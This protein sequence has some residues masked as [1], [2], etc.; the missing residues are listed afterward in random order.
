MNG[1][2]FVSQIAAADLNG[3][4]DQDLI[5][6]RSVYVGQQ[7][8][9]VTV[10]VGDGHGKFVDNTDALF[11]GN[12]PQTQNARE[13]VLADF[14]HDG[15]SDVFVADHG[16]D[17]SP[18]PGF[19]NTLI[20]SAPGGTL[21]NATTNLPQASDF[22][23]SGAAGDVNGDG[24]PDLYV[25]NVWGG[26]HV[27]PRILVN[28]GSGHFA[29]GDGLLPATQTDVNSRT[30]TSSLFADVNGDG[31][32]D[33]ILGADNSTPD[34]VV[35]LNDRT[36]H[37]SLLPAALPPKP[38]GTDAL[39]YDIA[40]EDINGD[41][42]ADLLI[43]FTRAIPPGQP[44]S[45]GSW[46]QVLIGN[47]DGTFRDET[48]ARLPQS[49]N[50]DPWATFLEQ[51]DLNRDGRL[52]F[53]LRVGGGAGGSPLLYLLDP[54]AGVFQLGPAVNVGNQLWTF[55]DA[56]GDGSNDIVA[57]NPSNG[58]VSLFREN[59]SSPPAP[60][61]PPA[62]DTTPPVLSVLTVHPAT[63]RVSKSRLRPRAKLGTTISY[64]A[65]ESVTAIFTVD[66][67]LPGVKRGGRCVAPRPG[68]ARSARCTR[69]VPLPGS[70]SDVDAAGGSHRF[71]Y[72]GR[73]QGN[74]L[75][76]GAYRLDATAKDA[77]GNVG[78]VVRAHFR[79]VRN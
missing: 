65:S 1:G 73:L 58:A 4:G 25:G 2:G 15:R 53:G 12:V 37:F 3:D 28:D 61:L 48:S 19:Q 26:S 66:R 29:V 50:N 71:R 55:V 41:G 47:G 14:N 49:D 11:G 57:A 7:T 23:H 68:R 44:T 35:L 34:S 60:P 52:D 54:A 30:Y 67:A 76:L 69:F 78:N 51:H 20:L 32:Q 74:P 16:D 6:T 38:F 42:R 40:T 59:R 39:A 62:H 31:K 79:V 56:E 33:L 75:R 21:A 24:A 43:A 70:F 9:P 27:P 22:T 46:V 13:L 5:L 77:A 8:F 10:L 72:T 18:F 36:G 17:Q 63:F 45:T 64:S